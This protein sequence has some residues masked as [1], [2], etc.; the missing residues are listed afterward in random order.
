[1]LKTLLQLC[2][3]LFYVNIVQNLVI[4]RK[5]FGQARLPKLQRNDGTSRGRL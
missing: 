4:V 1:M 3:V 2:M 5:D